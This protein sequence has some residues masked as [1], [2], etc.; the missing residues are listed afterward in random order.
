MFDLLC[1]TEFVVTSSFEESTLA[2]LPQ[3]KAEIVPEQKN[4]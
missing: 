2:H 1:G 3:I 4:I